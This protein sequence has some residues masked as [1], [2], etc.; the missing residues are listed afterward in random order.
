MQA[1]TEYKLNKQYLQRLIQS[2]QRP[3]N[4][5]FT[6]QAELEQYVELSTSSV[7]YLLLKILRIEDMNADHAIS[8]MAKAQGICNMLR[9]LAVAHQSG[10]GAL[11]AIPQDVLL[12][13]GCSYERI[14]RQRADDV[15][16]QNCIF[17]VAG[18]ANIHLEKSRNLSDKVP[19]NAK[20]LFLPAVAIGRFLER[21]R[22]AN[23]RLNEPSVT[24][25]DSQ[26]P[27]VIYWKR[28]RKTY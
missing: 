25:R 5:M 20:Q 22:R 28:F 9:T 16:V 13:H 4:T 11:P 27:L 14:L 1:V 12:T 8:H 10:L 24:K 3:S 2:R 23:F 7:Y 21:L 6:T 26:L 15:A 18:M 17:D 19:A